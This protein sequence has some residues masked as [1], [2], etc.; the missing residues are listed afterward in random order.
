MRL[1]RMTVTEPVNSRDFLNTPSVRVRACCM[2]KFVSPC[3][4]F[5]HLARWVSSLASAGGL[6]GAAGGWAGRVSRAA[7]ERDGNME[8]LPE[9]VP[10]AVPHTRLGRRVEVDLPNRLPL[11]GGRFAEVANTSAAGVV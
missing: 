8:S 5:S 4:A 11:R 10:S 7:S 1:G 9:R 2:R 3:A 6:A